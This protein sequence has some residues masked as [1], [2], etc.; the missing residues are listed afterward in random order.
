MWMNTSNLYVTLFIIQTL[1]WITFYKRCS[2]IIRW[3]S[4]K[5]HRS[6][7]TWFVSTKMKMI[8][9]YKNNGQFSFTL[10]CYFWDTNSILFSRLLSFVLHLHAYI[11][12][13]IRDSCSGNIYSSKRFAF[14]SWVI[15]KALKYLLPTRLMHRSGICQINFIEVK[16]IV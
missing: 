5:T 10:N 9:T 2:S 3:L 15:S 11:H 1:E 6:N 7:L 14:I 4:K 16:K 13:V 12:H 8:F